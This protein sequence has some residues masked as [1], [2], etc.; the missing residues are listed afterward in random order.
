MSKITTDLI[1]AASSM[2]PV[3]YNEYV[4]WKKSREAEGILIPEHEGEKGGLDKA[5]ESP[6]PS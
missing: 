3:A 6:V 2:G 5:P 4:E 1:L